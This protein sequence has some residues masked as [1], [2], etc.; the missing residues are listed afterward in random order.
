[1]R[2]LFGF[3]LKWISLT[4]LYDRQVNTSQYILTAP[5]FLSNQRQA[6]SQMIMTSLEALINVNLKLHIDSEQ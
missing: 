4:L 6:I 1:M 2:I 3:A 5:L